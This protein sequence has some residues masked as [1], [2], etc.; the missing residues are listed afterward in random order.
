HAASRPVTILHSFPTRRSSDLAEMSRNG[1]SGTPSF[2]PI[3]PRRHQTQRA[4]TMGNMTTEGLLNV[5]S[6]KQTRDKLNSN[7]LFIGLFHVDRKSTR[8]NSSHVSI[9][10]AVF[11]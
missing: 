5:A 10:Y 8:L 11:C 9:S 6:T 4:S 3:R 1:A 2:H 7:A